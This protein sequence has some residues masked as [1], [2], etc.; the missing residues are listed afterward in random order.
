MPDGTP[1][2]EAS[3]DKPG[4]SGVA[5]EKSI[6]IP[7]SK[8]NEEKRIVTGVV[9]QPE[10]VDGQGDIVSAEVIE[11]TAHKFLMNYVKARAQIGLMHED[12]TRQIE[13]VELYIAPAEFKLGGRKVKK[14]SWLMSV[15]IV[16]DEVWEAV[17]SGAITGFSIKGL[18]R[19]MQVAA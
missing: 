15:F 1:K 14:G 17:R 18:A 10:E 9:L 6:H 13:V 11:E 7:I 19:A 3:E 5:T 12:F 16:D 2:E 8:V 4:T